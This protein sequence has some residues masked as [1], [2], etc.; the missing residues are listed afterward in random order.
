MRKDLVENIEAGVA[1]HMA[2]NTLSLIRTLSSPDSPLPNM[3]DGFTPPTSVYFS[4][5][6]A[7]VRYPASLGTWMYL[8]LTGLSIFGAT[9]LPDPAP[10]LVGNSFNRKFTMI[11]RGA[12]GSFASFLFAIVGA[13]V[14][15][16]L[17]VF[18]GKP[19][20]WFSRAWLPIPLYA[21]PALAGA[22]AARIVLPSPNEKAVISSTSV[23]LLSIATTLHVA[24]Y[25]SGI[26]LVL[27]GAPLLLHMVPTD[28]A[29]MPDWIYLVAGLGALTTGTQV[30]ASVMDVFVP[31]TGRIGADVPADHVIASLVAILGSHTF[32]LVPAFASRYSKRSAL[33]GLAT[34]SILSVML[35]GIY[36][37]REPF[38]ELH[39]KRLYVI[40]MHNVCLSVVRF[41]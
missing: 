36:A 38:D 34:L 22:L 21:P 40:H 4:F 27:S 2:E 28:A 35:V 31:L 3:K 23:L 12:I 6:G 14:V 10:A 37:A 19:L 33:R 20:S 26:V 13:N 7:F 30:S 32:P 41:G 29:R 11:G 15:A 18:L 8:G 24:G 39:Q 25:G 5:M 17:M 16:A 1:Q 9:R